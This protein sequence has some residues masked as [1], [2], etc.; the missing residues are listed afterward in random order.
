MTDRTAPELSAQLALGLSLGSEASF[1]NAVASKRP[2]L[3][4]LQALWTQPA[5]TVFLHGEAGAGKSWTLYAS[6]SSL[7]P[8][9]AACLDLSQLQAQGTPELLA[10]LHGFRLLCLDGVDTIV[11]SDGY[12]E[13][14][15][16]LFNRY[17]DSGGHLVLSS[18]SPARAL[19]FSLPDLKSRLNSMQSIR[20][21]RPE[22]Q[23]LEWMI[24]F[25]L[26]ERGVKFDPAVLRYLVL[27][28]P[29]D[30]HTV[31]SVVETLDEAAWT[32]KKSLTI[33]FVRQTLGFASSHGSSKQ[34]TN[35]S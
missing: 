32:F 16:H 25:K 19:E 23:E 9:E 33:P 20:L 17:R 18:R 10:E 13:Q 14:L 26:S 3:G 4:M 5:S 15:F 31:N 27:R 24:G 7:D 28:L 2:V 8:T 11:G 34:G 1:A 21:P 12:E 35:T 30:L 29:R 22:D 6:V